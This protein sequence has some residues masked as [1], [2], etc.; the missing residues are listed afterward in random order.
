MLA[1]HLDI[2]SPV[3]HPRQHAGGERKVLEGSAVLRDGELVVGGAIDVVENGFREPPRGGAGD[4]G[5][6][7][8]A[9]RPV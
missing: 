6:A 5:R 7:Y 1:E 2:Q 9:K 4:L 3:G 8:G